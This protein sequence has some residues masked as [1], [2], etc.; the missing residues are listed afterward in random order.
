[1]AFNFEQD[2][3]IVIDREPGLSAAIVLHRPRSRGTVKLRSP[4]PVSAPK[5]QP[6]Y[7]DDPDDLRRMI[8]GVGLMRAILAER[9]LSD[10]IVSELTPGSSTTTDEDI[11]RYIREFG[12]C[13]WHQVG[14]CSMGRGD[15][16]V[17]D[18]TL[19]VRGLAGLRV[20]DASIMP[21]IP[22]GNTNAPAIMIAEKAADLIRSETTGHPG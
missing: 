13:S 6:A 14:T 3:R 5:L 22:T 19:R 2:G 1:M 4:N 8:L 21:A 20:V 16:A 17:T 18:H 7:L 11:T 12:N 10:R 15:E 9:P